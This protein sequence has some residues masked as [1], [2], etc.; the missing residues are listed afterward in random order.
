MAAYIELFTALWALYLWECF[1]FPRS[2][3]WMFVR[4]I[5]KS[6]RQL[7]RILIG[8]GGSAGGFFVAPP[9]SARLPAES[10][11]LV[12]RPDYRNVW[13][14]DGYRPVAEVAIEEFKAARLDGKEIRFPGGV[15][16]RASS[17]AMARNRLT[18]I[19]N[20][21]REDP[22]SS[23]RGMW[24]RSLRHR[25][26][27]VTRSRAWG[28]VF[29]VTF[30]ATLVF[31]LWFIALPAAV[32]LNGPNFFAL[33]IAIIAQLA[34]MIAALTLVFS[35]WR[36][37]PELKWQWVLESLVCMILPFRAARMTD[38]IGEVVLRNCDPLAISLQSGD[39]AVARMMT[40]L[41]QLNSPTK[42]AASVEVREYLLPLF[43][44]TFEAAGK[45]LSAMLEEKPKTIIRH[46]NDAAKY[47]P[48]CHAT[49]IE[50]ITTCPDCP[51]VKTKD[52][53]ETVS[54]NSQT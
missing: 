43:S 52:L 27:L 11:G 14:L 35:G 39:R 29:G 13:L 31:S 18:N 34:S 48:S 30:Q 25:Q 10:I 23:L 16:W 4:V 3:V 32:F 40:V 21:N 41:R 17:P 36:L 8:F 22:E 42:D 49:F 45:D 50:T 47:C 19:R 37:A 54:E 7:R 1:T 51:G 26:I 46:T 28:E 5:F 33:K 20:V 12:P 6:P 38:R 9:W 24:T 53:K 15:V 44:K 2:G